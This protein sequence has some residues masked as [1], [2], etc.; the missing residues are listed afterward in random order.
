M[1]KYPMYHVGKF[2][3]EK[4]AFYTTR[5]LIPMVDSVNA[6]DVI[7]LNG[8]KPINGVTPMV[9]GSCGLEVYG[10]DDLEYR[11]APNTAFT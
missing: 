11:D 6:E 10:S 5:R 3:C 7:L 2:G 1:E 9:C 4:V 8:E